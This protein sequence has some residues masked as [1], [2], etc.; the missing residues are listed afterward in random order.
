[1]YVCVWVC[2]C[3]CVR[4]CVN[5]IMSGQLW[6]TEDTEESNREPFQALC[7]PLRKYTDENHA[8]LQQT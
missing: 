2:V 3:V 4:V 6:A 5:D 8:N 1:M 7:R